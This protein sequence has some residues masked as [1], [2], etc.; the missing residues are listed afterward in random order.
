L[1]HQLSLLGLQFFQ[2]YAIPGNFHIAA[3]LWLLK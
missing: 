1:A 2:G 3:S